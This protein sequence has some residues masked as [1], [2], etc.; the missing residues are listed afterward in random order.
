MRTEHDGGGQA[1]LFERL[2]G[3]FVGFVCD[4]PRLVLTCALFAGAL[5]LIGGALLFRRAVKR[6]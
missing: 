5:S 1:A 3:T 4:R 2:L 6:N